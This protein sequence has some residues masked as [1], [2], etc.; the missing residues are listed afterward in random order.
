MHE[1]AVT[2]AR[3][4]AR[5]SLSESA[6]IRRGTIPMIYAPVLPACRFVAFSL[7]GA[8]LV[9]A[10]VLGAA[11]AGYCA[12]DPVQDLTDMSIEDL[13]DIT[14]VTGKKPET[15]SQMPAAVFVITKEDIERYGYRTLAQALRRISGFYTETDRY[16]SIIG[17]RGYL[18]NG[19]LNRRVLVLVDGHKVNDSLYG[20]APVDQ[21]LPVDLRDIERIEV[22]KGPGSAL[23]GSEALLCVINCITK[24]ASDIGGLQVS[25]DL[26][27]RAGQHL[28]YGGEFHGGLEIAGAVTELSSDGER[29]IYFADFDTPAYN[30]GIAEGLDGEHVGRG[31][32]TMSRGGLKLTY[33][34]VARL[35]DVATAHWSSVFNTPGIDV[36]DERRH[37]ELSYENPTPYGKNG[38]LFCRVYEDKY[39]AVCHWNTIDPDISPDLL[40]TEG[41]DWGRSWGA[42]ARYSMSL[43]PRVSAIVGIEHLEA[44]TQRITYRIDP[45]L[46]KLDWHGWY[47]LDS[48][49]AQVDWDATD[50]LRLVA[51]TRL[52][53]HSI[54]GANWSPRMG[55]IWTVTPKTTAKL[56]YGR[57]FRSPSMAEIATPDNPYGLYPEKIKTTELVLDHQVGDSGR[58]VTSVFAYDMYDLIYKRQNRNRINCRGIETQYDYRLRNGGSGYFGLSILNA[59]SINPSPNRPL[60]SSPHYVAT[61]GLSMPVFRNKAFLATDF[62]YV[63]ARRTNLRDEADAYLLGNLTLT[64]RSL[65]E[66][67]DVTFSVWNMFDKEYFANGQ[68]QNVQDLIPQGGRA[69]QC[70]ISRRL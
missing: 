28:A 9:A 43:S 35:K 15:I 23:W 27:Y 57:A 30:N 17:A 49:Y 69:F 13:M 50:S 46:L 64:S 40:Y 10:L 38:K 21:D 63:G 25:Q 6:A 70:S 20:Q 7:L 53:D 5:R 1:K 66:G 65:I 22:V 14:I 61:F 26:G 59:E 62:Q 3:L 51:G 55:M 58:L 44:E 11:T 16:I 42:E 37:L 18:P 45:Y 54:F 24:S 32:L 8:G 2:Y 36:K 60:T 34:H 19:D 41:I 68:P 12:D 29:R 56:L 33:G 52:D 47:N 4:V 31:Y 39:N 67:Y 48:Y